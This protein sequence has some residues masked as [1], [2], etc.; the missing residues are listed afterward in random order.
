MAVN[1]PRTWLITYDI[2]NPK[3]LVR[4]HRFL[5]RHATPVQYSVFLF[6]GS[7]A[8][9]GRLMAD[10]ET[11]IDKKTDDVRGYQLPAR[12]QID[13]F[14][15]GSLPADTHLLSDRSPSLDQLLQA[16]GRC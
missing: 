5:R 3:R 13:T 1:A 10:I 11:R 4:L 7:A 16:T 6:E 12:L 14:G 8:Q 15:R 2:T 9:M